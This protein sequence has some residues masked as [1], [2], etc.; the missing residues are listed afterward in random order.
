M[1][2]ESYRIFALGD[3]ALTVEFG[4]E[5]SLALNELALS[6]AAH[7]N[8]NPFPGFIEAVPAYASA[9]VFYDPVVVRKRLSISTN[10]FDTVRQMVEEALECLDNRAPITARL[11]E[12]PVNFG[13]GNG[14]DL[15]Y[16]SQKCGLAESEI[17]SLFISKTYRVYMLGFLPGFAYLGEVDE[18]ISVPRKTTPRLAVPRGSVGI[19]GRQTGIYPLE[20][21]GG[22]Q[23]IGRTDLQMFT[24]DSSDPCILRP[25]DSVKFVDTT[26]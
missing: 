22:W 21:P 4:Q 10:V 6:V 3:G 16:I 17:I 25:G 15:T 1:P 9:S 18:R 20:S 19:A 24:P 5:I 26:E 2:A 12:I 7:F 23:L 14:P 11:I 8:D 13:G